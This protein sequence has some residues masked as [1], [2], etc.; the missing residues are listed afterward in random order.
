[1]FNIILTGCCA[2][3]TD[4][5]EISRVLNWSLQYGLKPSTT[6]LSI[7]IKALCQTESWDSAF[8][9]LETAPKCLGLWPEARIY[10]Q[11]L[12]GC[13]K[14]GNGRKAVEAYSAM[15]KAVKAGGIFV[16]ELTSMR[17]LASVLPVASKRE[18]PAST[19]SFAGL[20]DGGN[21]RSMAQQKA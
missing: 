20:D 4:A 18:P 8:E 5:G 2:E 13:V 17:L 14:T 15:A 7:L 12:Q 6:T 9:L 11:L 19:P 16:D 3:P 1:M 21:S 10:A